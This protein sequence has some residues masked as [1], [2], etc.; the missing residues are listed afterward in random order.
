[1]KK[2]SF[3]LQE[4]TKCQWTFN[5]STLDT[6]L[7]NYRILMLRRGSEQLPKNK[8]SLLPKDV[9]IDKCLTAVNF[10]SQ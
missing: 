10:R 2:G 9:I 6:S 3:R 7:W 1:M 4:F 8:N 5:Y